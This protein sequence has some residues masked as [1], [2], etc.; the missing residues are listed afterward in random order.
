MADLPE[1]VFLGAGAFGVPTLEALA[2]AGR[3]A[4][5]VSQPDREAGR[6][7]RPT[8]TPI[9]EF[10]MAHGLPLLRT[11]DCSAPEASSRIRGAAADAAA[12][13]GASGRPQPGGAMVVIAFGQKIG[14]ALPDGIFAI[15]LH[16]S[17][18][19]RGRGAAP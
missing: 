4:L 5:V 3:V 18:L 19:P 9:S 14:P 17:L 6:G 8:P 15:T 1:V 7:K 10:A 12:R 13:A 2:R 11:E 16:V